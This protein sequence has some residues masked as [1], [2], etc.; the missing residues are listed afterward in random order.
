VQSDEAPSAADELTRTAGLDMCT[1]WTPTAD[2]YLGSVSKAHILEV[3]KEAVSAQAA[4]P[5]MKLKKATLA[6]VAEQQLAGT[7]WLPAFLRHVA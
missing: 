5:L 1:W 4:V 7:G 6:K 3:V 2:N